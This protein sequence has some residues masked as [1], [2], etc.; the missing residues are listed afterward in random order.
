MRNPRRRLPGQGSGRSAS[1]CRLFRRQRPGGS[2]VRDHD[3]IGR[4]ST[5]R[6]T[7]LYFG[8]DAGASEGFAS[9]L[10]LFGGAFTIAMSAVGM[11]AARTFSRIAGFSILISSGAV[12][13]VVGVGGAQALSGALYYMISSTFAVAAFFLLIELLNR[14]R[15]T[16]APAL[17]PPV[18]EDEYRDP[19]EDGP[20]TD[21]VGIVIPAAVAL[22]SGGFILCALLLAGLPPLSGFV[23][24]LAMMVGLAQHAAL[25]GWVLIALLA[26]SSFAAI[27]ALLRIGIETIWSAKDSVVPR[28]RGVEFAAIAGLLI[29]CIVMTTHGAAVMHYTDA[30]VAWLYSPQDYVGAVL[31]PHEAPAAQIEGA[32]R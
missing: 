28:V 30:T 21:E 2:A 19:Y 24:K 17:P 12:L 20:P 22:I 14:A 7:F 8:P 23:G 1:G 6:A 15:G 32:A 26:L 18:F 16:T 4:L 5:L 10:L 27:I 3:E 25:A 29:I 11:L 31:G 13:A 9:P